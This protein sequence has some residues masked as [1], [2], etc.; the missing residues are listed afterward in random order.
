MKKIDLTYINKYIDIYSGYNNS[1]YG[2][3]QWETSGSGTKRE[4]W[5]NDYSDLVGSLAH[6]GGLYNYGASA[7]LFAFNAAFGSADNAIGFHLIC[8]VY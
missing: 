8:V 7:G 4:S 6:R 3:A 1:K 5:F 2:I